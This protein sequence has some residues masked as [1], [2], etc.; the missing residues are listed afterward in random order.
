MKSEIGSFVVNGG[1][2]KVKIKKECFKCRTFTKDKS[3]GKCK[4]CMKSSCPG[5]AP[6]T[7]RR[8]RNYYRKNGRVI[9]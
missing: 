2:V 8:I 1:G 5:W 9:K 6:D 4:C 7:T 3:H